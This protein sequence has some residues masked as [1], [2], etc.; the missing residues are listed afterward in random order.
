MNRKLVPKTKAS[1]INHNNYEQSTFVLYLPLST[2]HS[3]AFHLLCK[4]NFN[5][6]CE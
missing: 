6:L 4:Y 1:P 5:T 3:A 2:E